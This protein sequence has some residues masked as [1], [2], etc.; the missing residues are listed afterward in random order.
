MPCSTVMGRAPTRRTT[1]RSVFKSCSSFC[2]TNN[3]FRTVSYF[4]IIYIFPL[5]NYHQ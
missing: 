3:Y 1:R 2:H 4:R 5:D